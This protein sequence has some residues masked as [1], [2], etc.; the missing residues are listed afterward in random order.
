MKKVF[1]NSGWTFTAPELEGTFKAEVPGCLH[2]DLA[3]AGIVK[4]IF[5]R[6]NNDKYGWV[7]N[8]SPTYELTFDAMPSDNVRLTFFQSGFNIFN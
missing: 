8:C 1:L 2:T 5:Y 4:D 6:D 7:E 3:K